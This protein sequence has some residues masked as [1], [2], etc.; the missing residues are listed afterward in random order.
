MF[1]LVAILTVGLSLFDGVMTLRWLSRGVAEELN[2][3]MVALIDYSP[4]AFLVIKLALLGSCTVLLYW[5]RARPMAARSLWGSLA[6]HV[7]I[8]WYHLGYS[9]GF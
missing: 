7:G 4:A 5:Q 9:L 2:P 1:S 3:V 6:L 8:A